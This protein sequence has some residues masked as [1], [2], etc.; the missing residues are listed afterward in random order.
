MSSI[1]LGNFIL[2][3]P[4]D[5]AREFKRYFSENKYRNPDF[6]L[7]ENK[8]ILTYLE[9]ISLNVVELDHNNYK[10]MDYILFKF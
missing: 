10:Y 7:S 5:K 8:F 2:P 1:K 9:V 3:V 6:V 4:R